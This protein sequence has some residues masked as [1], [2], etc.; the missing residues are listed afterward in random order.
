MASSLHG[1]YNISMNDHATYARVW[2]RIAELGDPE[3]VRAEALRRFG[4]VDWEDPE[5]VKAFDELARQVHMEQARQEAPHDRHELSPTMEV[6]YNEES[7]EALVIRRD[8]VGAL[9]VQADNT[10]MCIVDQ[11]SDVLGVRITGVS[12]E[13][14]A[15]V[16]ECMAYDH[17]CPDLAVA[18]REL[19]WRTFKRVAGFPEFGPVGIPRIV[20]N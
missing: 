13:Q 2:R 8:G 10:L 17:D 7:R 12:C 5:Q 3:T 18:G 16:L 15:A 4:P 20:K 11:Y 14:A 6:C 19:R 9:C 1:L